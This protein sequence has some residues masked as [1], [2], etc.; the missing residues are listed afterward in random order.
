MTCW[1]SLVAPLL[2]A[3]ATAPH[4]PLAP[5][6]ALQ[7]PSAA[8]PP[9]TPEPG[10][11]GVGSGYRVGPGDVLRVAVYGHGDLDQTLVV[12]PDGSFVFPLIGPVPA[13]GATTAE[14][15]GRISQRFARGLIRDAQV[16]VTVEQYRS[17][18]VYVVGEAARP[19]AYPLAGQTRI[20]EILARAGPLTKDASGEV[21]VVR[22]AGPVTKPVLPDPQAPGSA[23]RAASPGAPAAQ[24]LHVDLR[25]LEA[26][27][28]D[29]NLE[30]EPN[31]TVFIP[32]AEQVFV[33]GEVR[34]PGAV[35]YHRGITAR[36]AVALAG[37]FTDD[38]SKGSARVVR[39][40]LGRSTTLKIGFD[41]RLE[42]GDTVVV[43]KA[44]F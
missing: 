12:Q 37:G 8:L 42:P 24:V 41:E 34:S 28:L 43:K 3:Q 7:Q 30:L 33:T 21:L 29:Q 23:R 36:Q 18:I 4:A 31:D 10:P 5:R 32:A 20:V 27:R 14:L 26:G 19:G 22:P 25:A 39:D 2:L 17:K 15:E 38:A 35:T 6:P 16:S 1:L 9:V 13:D 40:L 44:W 11:T